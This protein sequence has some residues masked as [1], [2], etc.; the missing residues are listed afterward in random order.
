[1]VDRLR[2]YRRWRN[3]RLGLLLPVFLGALGTQLWLAAG[4]AAPAWLRVVSLGTTGLIVALIGYFLAQTLFCAMLHARGNRAGARVLRE[5]LAPSGRAALAAAALLATLNT[6]PYLIPVDPERA[7][8]LP[9]HR[10]TRFRQDWTAPTVVPLTETDLEAPSVAESPAAK[11]SRPDVHPVVETLPLHL[12]VEE[13]DS[14]PDVSAVLA[15]LSPAQE[16][17]ERRSGGQ[18]EEVYPRYRPDVTDGFQLILESDS[19]SRLLARLGVPDQGHPDEWLLPELRLEVSFFKGS[20]S[21]TEYALRF[22]VPISR[23]ESIRADIAVGRLGGHEYL[24]ESA[25]ES[26]QRVTIAYSVRAAGYTRQAPF[27]LAFSIGLA[28]DRYRLAG[29]DGPMDPRTRLSPYVAI[30][31]AIWQH[32]AA[33]LLLH[34]GYSIP[35]NATGGSSGVLDLAATIRIDLTEN[36]SIHAGYRY[37]V[38]RLRDYEDSLIGSR[39]RAD[40]SESFSGPLVGM[41]IRF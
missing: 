11:P 33:G 1:M 32:G 3:R 8:A 30:D 37:L 31:A 28:A 38:V 24:E 20:E 17:P 6:I 40:L 19:A 34:A 36:V 23:D 15:F 2:A 27:D 22:D 16:E 12:A 29:A 7:A 9:F 18:E 4:S 13:S 39:S 14:R 5:Q 26:W 10:G 25:A 41:D 35:V 21:G